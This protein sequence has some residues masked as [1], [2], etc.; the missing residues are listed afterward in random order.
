MASGVVLVYDYFLREWYT[1]TN[2]AAVDAVVFQSQAT[3]LQSTGAA[4]QETA[5]S[6]TDN[7][8]FIKMRIKLSW[9]ALAG[10]QGFQ[11][12][13]NM[14]ILGDYISAHKLQV[15][16][17]YDFNPNPTQT[18]T[19]DA[20]AVL[21]TAVFGADATFGASSV[22]GGVYPSYQFQVSLTQQKC[23]SVQF[24]LED[25]QQSNFGE[26]YSLSAITLQVGLKT[27]TNRLPDSRTY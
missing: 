27:G 11:R 22:Y 23:Q 9:L 8:N 5:G 12:V 24:T 10:I 25:V 7:G 1:F 21:G 17:A 3:Y 14:A 4:F 16:V 26:G 20:T 18:T 19:I 2:I 15:Q 6:Y 13:Y